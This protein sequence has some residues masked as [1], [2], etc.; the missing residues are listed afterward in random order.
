MSAK[1]VGV[2]SLTGSVAANAWGA[3]PADEEAGNGATPGSAG[4]ARAT[5]VAT[6]QHATMPSRLARRMASSPRE[7]HFDV[8]A[9]SRVRGV[10]QARFR[11]AVGVEFVPQCEPLAKN[12]TRRGEIRA[13]MVNPRWPR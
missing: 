6:Q 8:R 1:P 13:K 9:I 11:V 12:P 3:G 5:S 4:Y 7:Q 2:R 10:G